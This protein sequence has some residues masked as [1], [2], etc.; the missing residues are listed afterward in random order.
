MRGRIIYIL[1]MISFKFCHLHLL[2]LLPLPQHTTPHNVSETTCL[3][4][5]GHYFFTY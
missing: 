1:T 5:S 4:L 3:L 2:G